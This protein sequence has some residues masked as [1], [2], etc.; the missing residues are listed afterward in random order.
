[1][2]P[3][4]TPF[5]AGLLAVALFAAQPLLGLCNAAAPA[6][7][8]KPPAAGKTLKPFAGERDFRQTMARLLGR[9]EARVRYAPVAPASPSPAGQPTA[10]S[11]STTLDS[12]SVT[13]SRV[14][15]PIDTITNVQTQGVDEGD[16][17]K[18]QGDYLIVLRRGR[19]FTLDTSGDGLRAVS[20]VDAFAPGSDP[21]GTWYD[22]MLVA[23]G[24]VVVI[25]YS[26]DRGGTEIGLFDL[27]GNGT[28]RY[29]ATYQLRSSD[30]YSARNY[31]SRLIGK[32]LIFY[33]PMSLDDYESEAPDAQLP[34][35]R[36]WTRG[37]TPTDF[38]RILP[39]TRIYSSPGLLDPDDIALHAVTQCELGGARMR[40]RSSAVLGPDSRVFYVSEDAVYIWSSREPDPKKPA[41]ANAAVFRMPLD[42]RAPSAL[43]ASGSPIDQM[44]FLQRDGWLN[45]L[46][47]NEGEGEAMWASRMRPGDLA[48]LRV[49]LS[50]FGDG[51]GIARRDAYRPLP[52]ANAYD[53][54]LHARFIGDWLV[55][56]FGGYWGE[57]AAINA[58]VAYALRYAR[59]DPL[60][61]LRLPH[62][63]QRVDALGRDAIL[64]GTEEDS[65]DD[66]SASGLHFTSVRLDGAARIAG[67]YLQAHTEQ[68]DDRS[69][70]FFYRPDDAD[71]GLLGLPV[72]DEGGGGNAS[73][74]FLRNQHLNL[75]PAGAL[76]SN[77][78]AGKDSDDG[79]VISCVDWYGNAR[80]IFAGTRVYALLGY[81]L[82]EGRRDNGRIVERRRVD[83]APHA[84]V[85]R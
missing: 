79:C 3:Q 24:T 37:A 60:A 14:P 43:R 74:L 33:A 67:H 32:T 15:T 42:G 66:A 38:R 72:V 45:V 28:L 35:L 85:S 12:I 36:Q 58:K 18:K 26:Y 49:R 55:F 40:C 30:Y 47:S 50:E 62:H 17:V 8:G 4:K 25:G 16:I 51:R 27:Q 75:S 5:A 23:D 22:E 64:I 20:S 83:F 48:L 39:A 80:P 56:G 6:Q 59:R 73:V 71:N 82:V 34:A 10:P 9:R 52:Q 63:V 65:E 7:P 78:G 1:M 54:D 69:H 44:A 68:G 21:N 70:G 19:L 11:G 41:R 61:T 53:Y 57:K 81:E 13:G 84:A 31:A 46:V 2:T 76:V 29:R 77:G